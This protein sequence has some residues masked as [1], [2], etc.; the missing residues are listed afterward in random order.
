[1]LRGKACVG[2]KNMEGLFLEESPWEE[3]PITKKKKTATWNKITQRPKHSH[4]NKI[5]LW[6]ITNIL[7]VSAHETRVPRHWGIA[8]A[9][10]RP[11]PLGSLSA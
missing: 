11:G 3:V 5:C 6:R 1:M 9:A 2:E 10:K 4:G 8:T 7:S